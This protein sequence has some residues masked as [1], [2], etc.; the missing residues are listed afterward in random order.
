MLKSCN[1]FVLCHYQQK[2]KNVNMSTEL[3]M[4]EQAT[5]VFHYWYRTIMQDVSISV[6]DILSIVIM[7]YNIYIPY[8]GKFIEE[9]CGSGFTIVSETE[10]RLEQGKGGHCTAKLDTPIYMNGHYIYYWDIVITTEKWL[11]FDEVVGVVS[12]KCNN[13]GTHIT[14]ELIDPYGVSASDEYRGTT[15]DY[16]VRDTFSELIR[17]DVP[18]RMELDTELS[19]ITFKQD[20][21]SLHTMH[22][23]ERDAW[24]PMVQGGFDSYGYVFKLIPN[25]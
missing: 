17:P 22:L 10:L 21:K 19:T 20:N 12:D 3:A 11:T 13:I 4:N 1:R 23:P 15:F 7:Y 14:S 9:N 8:I 16:P 5:M 18:I 2:H 6:D 24:Y 25:S